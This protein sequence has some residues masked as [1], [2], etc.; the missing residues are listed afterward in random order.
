[1]RVPGPDTRVVELRV[2][3]ILGT[4]GDA[5]TDSVASVDVAGDGVGR[6]VRPADRLRRP[7]PGPMLS[8]GERTVPRVVE[9]YVWGGMTSGGW[10]KATWALLF[11]FAL[12]N[13]AH[14]MLPSPGRGNVLSR[15]L[16][17]VLRALLRLSALLLTMLMV[18]Q[19]AV[20]GLDL[21]AAQ[22]LRPDSGC[23]GFVPDTVREL[24]VLRA[25][26]GLLPVALVVLLMHRL[27]SVSWHV[28]AGR[29]EGTHH[30]ATAPILPGSNVVSDPDT[31]A[32]RALHVAGALSIVAFLALGGPSGWALD[33]RWLISAALIV[34]SVVG[35]LVM[36]DP[37]GSNSHRR[38]QA[39]RAALHRGPRRTL[40]S[41][42]GLVLLSVVVFPGSLSSALPGSGGTI[43]A[44]T[45]LMVT[46]CIVVA[47]LLVPAALLA[48]SGWKQVP[49]QLRPWAGGWMAAPMLMIACLLGSGFGAGLALSIRQALGDS[50]L[51][52][53]AAYDD[54]AIFWGTAAALLIA[55]GIVLVPYVL[56][57]NWRAAQTEGPVPDEVALLH[58]GRQQDQK[59]AAA[60]WRLA[61]LQRR[62]VHRALLVI[63]G[64]LTACTALTM[65]LR[66]FGLPRTAWSNWLIALGVATLAALAIGLLRMVFL[67]AT[68]R[69]TARYLGILCDLTL[70]WPREAHPVVPP[71]YALKVI[72]ELAARATEHLADPNTRVVLVGHSQG[73][74]LAAVAT[75]R[76]ME[77]LP[78]EDRER[79]GLVTAGSQ[80]QWAYPRAFPGVVPHDSLRDLSGSLGGRWRSLCR[81]TDSIGGA[82][83]TWNRQVFD[84]MLI[85]VGF[86]TDG[87]AGPL[88]AATR[89]PTGALVLGG[90][91]W[92]PD[93]QRGPFS[94][95]RWVPGVLGHTDYSG[96]PEWDRAVA[97]AAGLEAPTRA[98]ALPLITPTTTST[99]SASKASGPTAAGSEV[100]DAQG[101]HAQGGDGGSLTLVITGR[102]ERAASIATASTDAEAEAGA[103][104]PA[105]NGPGVDERT[106]VWNEAE[107]AE[108]SKSGSE[109]GTATGAGSGTWTGAEGD[110]G[111]ATETS[112]SESTANGKPSE[113]AEHADDSSRAEQSVLPEITEPRG[114]TAPWE[115]G[116]ALRSS[117]AER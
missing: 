101:V 81:G 2:H 82:V 70:F 34:F 5:L 109:N 65:L 41:V 11:P 51:L 115:R 23:L 17:G 108:E 52:L 10:G 71:C 48:R 103:E 117:S 20:V 37:T 105:G 1:M 60:A 73:S 24:D 38:G 79:V 114:R 50:S 21:L 47:V 53:P 74:L 26:V 31:A 28:S 4:T 15:G 56:V 72:P 39:F 46:T 76:L 57:R 77:S 102:G 8:A 99:P 98:A 36:D 107:A 61:D 90:D 45:A 106:R 64:V 85:G 35:V 32:L 104:S 66:Y 86:R 111:G 9:G 112:Q 29:S 116:L 42:S 84:G 59:S 67:A 113:A 75:A 83:S 80:L 14:W 55:V 87:T 33:P 96:D 100:A 7:V 58:A 16:S 3:G 62:N 43:D 13:V 25:A 91:H 95:R 54:L 92:L 94:F 12:A 49:A 30:S 27:S 110:S 89:G 6:I 18:A 19:L 68:E 69:K 78:E 63:A 88:P 97:M 40:M 93:P 44:I 22:C